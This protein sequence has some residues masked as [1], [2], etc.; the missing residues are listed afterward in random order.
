[1]NMN[2]KQIFAIDPGPI[3]SAYCKIDADTYRPLVFDKVDNDLLKERLIDYLHNGG[4]TVVC[5]MVS[6]YGKGV[7]RSIFDTCITI[8]ELNQIVKDVAG[9]KMTYINRPD[10]KKNICSQRKAKDSDVLRAL[11]SRFGNKGTKQNPGFFYG[12]RADIWQAFA[13]G[14]TYIDKLEASNI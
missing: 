5:E 4:K 13:L 8:G 12:F 10:V 3:Q 6:C 7:G 11:Q 2:E 9:M 14:V 1:M